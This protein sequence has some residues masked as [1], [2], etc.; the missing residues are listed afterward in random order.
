MEAFEF[1]KASATAEKY[2]TNSS[3]KII[4]FGNTNLIFLITN[5]KSGKLFFAGESTIL[6][7]ETCYFLF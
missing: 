6:N 4:T 3:L 1:F 7:F 5:L 2:F